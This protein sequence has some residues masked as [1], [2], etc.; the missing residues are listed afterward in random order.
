[1]GT[2][3]K[4]CVRSVK[5][6]PSP[7]ELDFAFGD[8]DALLVGMDAGVDGPARLKLGE[9]ETHMNRA[10]AATDQIRTAENLW[11]APDRAPV[12]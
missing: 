6:V 5:V 8:E 9:E 2:R 4:S 11:H 7:V 3:A 10:L 12:W 1:M